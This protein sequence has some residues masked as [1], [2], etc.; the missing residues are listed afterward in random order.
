[1]ADID[2]LQAALGP[3]TVDQATRVKVVRGGEVREVEL[4]VGVRGK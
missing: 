2:D 3:E 1:V 4:T